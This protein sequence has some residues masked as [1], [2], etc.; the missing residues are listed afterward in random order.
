MTHS[1]P[2][3]GLRILDLTSVVMGPYATQILGDLGADI[4]KLEPPAGDTTR[5]ISPLRNPDMGY[6]FLNLN[7]NKRSVVLDLKRPDALKAFFAIA[8]TVD[9]VIYNV[10]PKAMARLGITHAKLAQDNPR[11]ISMSLVGFSQSGPYADFPVYEDL[12]QGLTAIPSLLLE[13]GAGSPRYVPYA[14]NDR[15]VGLHA[16]I[17][18]LA[19]LLSRERTGRGQEIEIPMFETMAQGVIGEH[20]GGLTF[21]P[22]A[23]PVGYRR[24]MSK[25]RRPYPTRDG[26]VCVIIYTDKHWRSFLELVGKGQMIKDDPRLRD[27]GSRTQHSDSLYQLIEDE[28]TARSTQEWLTLLRDADIPVAP[29]HT[30][31]SLVSDP[32]LEATGFINKVVHPSEGMIR[33]PGVYGTWSDTPPAVTRHA[34]KLGEHSREVLREAGL[35]ATIISDLLASGGAIQSATDNQPHGKSAW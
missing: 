13:A 14:F 27:I 30:L 19:A 8:K 4:I 6:M 15:S 3:V 12:I 18:L 22:Q 33:Q 5:K 32:H 25:Q 26:H 10:R 11:L 7:R 9:V 24:S 21:E 28:M 29:L 35:S 2:L 17:A 31:E 16:G 23:G 1:G 20:L 34:P